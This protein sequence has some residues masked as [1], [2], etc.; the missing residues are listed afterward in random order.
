MVE[1]VDY[2]NQQP[3]T[4]QSMFRQ[5]SETLFREEKAEIQTYLNYLQVHTMLD[6]ASGIGRFTRFFSE[7][8]NR[9]I[10]VDFTEH[11]VQKNRRDHKDCANV[12]Y[13][14]ANALDLQIPKGSIDFVFFNWLCLYLNDREVSL[15]FEKIHH[16][17]KPHGEL[18][19]RE[20][21]NLVRTNSQA[22]DYFAIYRP[23][24]EY[25]GFLKRRFSIIHDD[26]L[27]SYIYEYGNPFQ[28][29]WH[30]RRI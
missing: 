15:L 4:I 10:S 28:C 16:W 24:A 3:A 22:K 12:E 30:C 5:N 20:S 29:Y 9:V 13:I 8:C 21:C 25:D 6:L 17:L 19:F 14:C 18:F 1:P 7:R 23:L 27:K 2:W 11:F 26:H